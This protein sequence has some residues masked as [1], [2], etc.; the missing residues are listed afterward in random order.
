MYILS[1]LYT[2]KITIIT[3]T[4]RNKYSSLKNLYNFITHSITHTNVEKKKTVELI[5]HRCL[6]SQTKSSSLVL[7]YTCINATFFVQFYFSTLSNFYFFYFF[8][9]SIHARQIIH[10]SRKKKLINNFAE[11]KNKSVAKKRS[12]QT[13]K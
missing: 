3:F 1:S 4:S 2:D 6:L 11:H 13:S 12:P 7:G 10:S 9:F 8:S 5:Q